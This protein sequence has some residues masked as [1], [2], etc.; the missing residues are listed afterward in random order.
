M[1]VNT[2]G[3]Q[4]AVGENAVATRRRTDQVERNRF[5]QRLDG[6]R[7]HHVNSLNQFDNYMNSVYEQQRQDTRLL[8]Q[9]WIE[10]RAKKVGKSKVARHGQNIANS[11]APMAQ[12]LLKQ[13]L[14]TQ[15]QSPSSSTVNNCFKASS[16]SSPLPKTS[17][18]SSVETSSAPPPVDGLDLQR[19]VQVSISLGLSNSLQHNHNE[20]TVKLNSSLQN[21]NSHEAAESGANIETYKSETRDTPAHAFEM[22]PEPSPVSGTEAIDIGD[23]DCFSDMFSIDEEFIKSLDFENDYSQES[24]LPISSDVFAAEEAAKA[25]QDIVSCNS[26]LML[27]STYMDSEFSAGFDSTGDVAVS[28]T[29]QGTAPVTPVVRL[30]LEPCPAGVAPP[31]PTLLGDTGP[32]AETLKQMAAHHQNQETVHYVTDA[33]RFAQETF[34]GRYQLSAACYLDAGFMPQEYGSVMKNSFGGHLDARMLQQGRTVPGNA[35]LLQSKSKLPTSACYHQMQTQHF[36]DGVIVP[37]SSL[38]HLQH[39]V[40]SHFDSQE[41]CTPKPSIMTPASLHDP[42]IHSG[43]LEKQFRLSQRP[44]L[45]SQVTQEHLSMSQCQQSM[46]MNTDCHAYPVVDGNAT[47]HGRVHQLYQ[48]PKQQQQQ[49]QQPC[50]NPYGHGA[51]YQMHSSVQ[52]HPMYRNVSVNRH[53]QFAVLTQQQQQQQ[54]SDIAVCHQITNPLMMEQMRYDTFSAPRTLPPKSNSAYMSSAEMMQ[55]DDSQSSNMMPNTTSYCQP[56]INTG[57]QQQHPSA[58]MKPM[59][60]ASVVT[61]IPAGLYAVGQDL[62]ASS[63]DWSNL[64]LQQQHLRHQYGGSSDSMSRCRSGGGNSVLPSYDEH[65]QCFQQR[66]IG[67]SHSLGSGLYGNQD[68][69]NCLNHSWTPSDPISSGLPKLHQLH[70]GMNTIGPKAMHAADNMLLPSHLCLPPSCSGPSLHRLP[71]I[72]ANGFHGTQCENFEFLGSLDAMASNGRELL[73]QN[74]LDN[75]SSIY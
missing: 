28:T 58:I 15:N 73:S 31:A 50:Y 62:C 5:L 67:A 7:R 9:N 45:R 40:H 48:Q 4:N 64:G 72:T 13:K 10:S 35:P 66:T 2:L 39:Q 63:T 54:H 18:E 65:K 42:N 19:G 1:P 30:P 51:A 36:A 12:K 38:Q 27:P 74:I 17:Q 8:H 49:Q 52:L 23:I 46:S 47:E 34:P 71:S 22:I 53:G 6:Y 57:Q 59:Q 3:F 44:Q 61:V 14:N 41:Y 26:D 55:H 68:L 25:K 70:H 56:R 60:S 43:A 16:S 24:K 69:A 20:I 11:T 21:T 29:L 37:S 33:N 75:L 32:A